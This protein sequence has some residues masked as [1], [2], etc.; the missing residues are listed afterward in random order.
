[1]ASIQA[2]RE[3]AQ[4]RAIL[5]QWHSFPTAP[6]LEKVKAHDEDACRAGSPKALGNAAVDAKA[7]IAASSPE[8]A[9]YVPDPRTA[10][11]VQLQ[12]SMGVW[13]IDLTGAVNTLWWERARARAAARRPW[14]A[15]LYPPGMEFDWRASCSIF[16]CPTVEGGAFVHLVA[17][18]EIK[19]IGRG[20][21]GALATSLRLSR[22]LPSLPCP[23]C[24]E[25]LEDDFHMVC[26][27][28]ITGSADCATFASTLWLEVNRGA[29][30]LATPLPPAWVDAHLP[31]LAV[32]LIPASLQ[33][34]IPPPAGSGFHQPVWFILRCFHLG[35]ARWLAER[36]RRRET[37]VGL[38]RAALPLPLPPGA[39]VPD[40]AAARPFQLS[41]A[42]LRAAERAAPLSPAVSLAPSGPQALLRQ[43]KRDALLALATWVKAHPHLRACRLEDGVSAVALLLLWEVDHNNTFPS[44]AVELVGRLTTFTKA[45]LTAVAADDE[46][47]RWLTSGHMHMRLTP[48]LPSVQQ[49]RWSVSIAPE[50]G[51]PY[52]V[53]W[54]GHL[55]G[56]VQRENAAVAQGRPPR[57]KRVAKPKAAP[58]RP[59]EDAPAP[60]LSTAAERVKRLRAAQAALAE[61]TA[62]SARSSPSS[63][64]SRARGWPPTGATAQQAGRMTGLPLRWPPL[65]PTGGHPHGV[66]LRSPLSVP[67]THP[68]A[69]SVSPGGPPLDR[70][71]SR[72][73]PAPLAIVQGSPDTAARPPVP[74]CPAAPLGPGALPRPSPH[75]PT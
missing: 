40:L 36:C 69:L 18:P 53:R 29:G 15:T 55:T 59:R 37:I 61:G 58:K 7:K 66:G 13:L 46:L 73:L 8:V 11:A 63:P 60:P 54:K 71:A 1:M 19:W 48:G 49:R 21:T 20:R 67:L 32:A 45:L 74:G 22:Q 62:S 68:S 6:L 3:R 12:D 51:E 31:Q 14:L 28:P 57:A 56:L 9:L 27:C 39:P 41:I 24:K 30:T 43:R 33:Q 34:F 72:A 50:V 38:E 44:A 4:V 35:M 42:E 5:Y 23:C 10:D 65:R 25:V 52:L 47:Q 16:T 26:G 75:A 64:A 70:V 17:P 2:C